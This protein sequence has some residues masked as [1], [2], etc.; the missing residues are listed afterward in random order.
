MLNEHSYGVVPIF[1]EDGL[2]KYLVIHQ[3]RGHWAFPKGHLEAGET[4][5]ETARRELKEEVGITDCELDLT[6]EFNQFYHFVKD[7][8]EID[9]QVNYWCG[10]VT[11]KNVQLQAKEVQEVAW[12]EF[13]PAIQQLTHEP[14]K[15][16]LRE[17][18]EYLQ[19]KFEK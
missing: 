12:L 16:L 19:S 6:Q 7:G 9:K 17:V 1:I 18:E 5:I 15:K 10:F 11:N 4:P 3:T 2:R 13:E 14:S 8:E